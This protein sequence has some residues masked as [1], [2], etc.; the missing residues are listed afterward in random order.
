MVLFCQ[1]AGFWSL[2]Y[3][4]AIEIWQTVEIWRDSQMCETC[5][6]SLSVCVKNAFAIYQWRDGEVPG[7]L[8]PCRCSAI[9]LPLAWHDLP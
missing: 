7:G 3:G 2:K 1:K 9:V 5:L 4:L 6:F 8:K